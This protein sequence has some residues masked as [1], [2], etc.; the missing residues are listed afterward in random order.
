[1]VWFTAADEGPKNVEGVRPLF[2]DAF[3]LF[4]RR[5]DGLAP[6][7]DAD[8]VPL[9]PGWDLH[10]TDP[11]V[12]A[13]AW[14]LALRQIRKLLI[15]ILWLRT[16]RA[17]TLFRIKQNTLNYTPRW[18]I[19]HLSPLFA[20]WPAKVLDELEEESVTEHHLPGSRLVHQ[21]CPHTVGVYLLQVGVVDVVR[22]TGSRKT[23]REQGLVTTMTG[24]QVLCEG[25]CLSKDILPYSVIA[26]TFCSVHIVPVGALFRALQQIPRTATA[27]TLHQ[28]YRLRQQ[29]LP[30]TSPLTYSALRTTPLFARVDDVG[31]VVEKF[32]PRV[33][34]EG[35]VVVK[36]GKAPSDL[37]FLQRGR[38]GLYSECGMVGEVVAP[39]CFLETFVAFSE[40]S[41]ATGIALQPCNMWALPAE[42]VASLLNGNPA[43]LAFIKDQ[44][45]TLRHSLTDDLLQKIPLFAHILSADQLRG[46]R[47]LFR[48]RV[49]SPTDC[50]CSKSRYCEKLVLLLSGKAQ[51]STQ[52]P[53]VFPPHTA[54]GVTLLLKHRWAHS[55]LAISFVDA[56]EIDRS[57]LLRYVASLPRATQ[58]AL[59]SA[60][61]NLVM[62]SSLTPVDNAIDESI[63]HLPRMFPDITQGT[64]TLYKD[65]TAPLPPRKPVASGYELHPV[66]RG[67]FRGW[68]E[69]FV[70]TTG[71]F[72]TAYY[73]K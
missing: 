22:W 43:A 58:T 15:P 26:A 38:V 73:P 68:R 27:D 65:P 30:I 32:I 6:L 46:L 19:L 3:Q 50:I 10:N 2:H 24:P 70:Y 67:P 36:A 14:C 29:W 20:G 18:G 49:Y 39:C 61:R 7:E 45:V 4:H 66:I 33:F 42:D 1:M 55:V 71:C 13:C 44:R 54:L 69:G 53:F 41:P 28:A 35:E 25:S 56:L 34:Q 16:H 5:H 37:L 60:T 64:R 59:V 17:R 47:P 48:N 31:S 51:A 9:P 57:V 8:R 23:S 11:A 52:P 12:V 21:G 63:A 72:G 62:D 40:A